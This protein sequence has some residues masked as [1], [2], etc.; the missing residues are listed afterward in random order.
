MAARSSAATATVMPVAAG[1]GTR[2]SNFLH[3][4][5]APSIAVSSSRITG[6]TA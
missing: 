3:C 6:K 4:M 1:N 5:S 2:T